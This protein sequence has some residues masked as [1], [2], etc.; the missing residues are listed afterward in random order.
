VQYAAA[1]PVN[2]E[3]RRDPPR[4][5]LGQ[6]A[7]IAAGRSVPKSR[8]WPNLPAKITSSRRALAGAKLPDG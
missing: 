4:A 6:F 3:A 8:M 1:D 5:K 7:L 2:L